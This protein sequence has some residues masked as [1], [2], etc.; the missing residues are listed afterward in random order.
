MSKQNCDRQQ[1][2]DAGC[3]DYLAKPIHIDQLRN[4]LSQYLQPARPISAEASI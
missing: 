1:C 3:D 2:L 4:L